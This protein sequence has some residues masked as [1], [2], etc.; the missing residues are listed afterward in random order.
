[1]NSTDYYMKEKNKLKRLI[2]MPNH[3]WKTNKNFWIPWK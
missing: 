3:Y 2:N 1:M